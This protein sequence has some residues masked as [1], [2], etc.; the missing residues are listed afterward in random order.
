MSRKLQA[1]LFVLGAALFAYL[2]ARIG[3]SRLADDAAHTGWMFIPIVAVYGFV[4][5]SSAGA[6]RLTMASDPNRPSL[7]RTYAILVSAGAINVL[8]PFI[9]MGGEPYRIAALTPWLGNQRAAGSVILHRMLNLLSYVLVWLTALGLGFVL[10]PRGSRPTVLLAVAAALLVGVIVLLLFGHRSGVLEHVLNG[11]QRI[12]LIRRVAALIEPRRAVLAK[13]DRQITDFYHDHPRR[14][15]QAVGLEYLSRC[16]FMVELV[17]IAASLGVHLG[18][19]RAFAIG[20]LEALLGNVL[21]FIPFE[22]G[23]REGAYFVLFRLFG[24]D[25]QLGLY[26]SI[27]SRVRDFTWIAA[28]L[29]LIW[30]S[31]PAHQVGRPA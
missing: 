17:L 7:W 30:V 24:F 22:L 19:L 31:R 4:Y 13:V 3:V 9:N 10:L 25:P 8:T 15:I 28:G 29:L 14:F 16:I 5:A 26:V 23:A 21:F 12:P 6:W 11:M 27:V 18:Y 20:G 2:I 1:A